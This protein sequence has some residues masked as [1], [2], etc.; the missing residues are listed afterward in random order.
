M[1][2]SQQRG[3]DGRS[4]CSLERGIFLTPETDCWRQ[5][6]VPGDFPK[7]IVCCPLSGAQIG[8]A[9]QSKT[10]LNCE[11]WD[12]EWSLEHLESKVGFHLA[13]DLRSI[14]IW[15]PEQNRVPQLEIAI[16]CCL[17]ELANEFYNGGGLSSV[18]KR[19]TNRKSSVGR[20]QGIVVKAALEL[21]F[22][23]L[24]TNFLTSWLYCPGQVISPF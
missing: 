13:I 7:F 18:T 21:K 8:D 10:D 23:H 5:W 20:T 22:L 12:G 15:G 11:A 4:R 16:C 3:R 2:G 17:L 6:E 1:Q 14:C 24:D 9:R 19:T